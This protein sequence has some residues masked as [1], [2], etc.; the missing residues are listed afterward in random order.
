MARGPVIGAALASLTAGFVMGLVIAWGLWPVQFAEADPVDLRATYKEDYVRMISAAYQ[1]NGNLAL[2]QQ[3]MIQLG[4]G[5]AVPVINGLV[6]R[7]RQ[8]GIVSRSTTALAGLAAALNAPQAAPKAT[9]ASSESGPTPAT[10]ATLPIPTFV[11]VERSPLTCQDQPG[12]VI[13]VYVRDARGKDLPNVAVEV[14]WASGDETLY[15]GLKPE[16]GVGYAD[17]Q[18]APGTYTLTILNATSP[19]VTGLTIAQ[20]PADCKSDRGASPR[21]WKLVFQ[22]Q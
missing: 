14:R 22:Q 10:I 21:G 7:D 19:A 16:R 8:T 9:T 11:L 15:T 4:M 12:A 17:L 5:N 1:V 18:A 20:P 13:K 3:R 6:T 2:A